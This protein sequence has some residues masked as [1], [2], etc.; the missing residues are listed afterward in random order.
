M[1]THVKCPHCG[2]RFKTGQLDVAQCS[3]VGG[4]CGKNF[5]VKENK[6]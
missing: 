3:T 1:S 6:D 5:I 2:Y 4:G